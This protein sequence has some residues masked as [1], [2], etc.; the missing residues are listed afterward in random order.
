MAILEKLKAIIDKRSKRDGLRRPVTTDEVA[1]A[2]LAIMVAL[3]KLLEQPSPCPEMGTRVTSPQRAAPPILHV[4]ETPAPYT[5]PDSPP[6]L[7]S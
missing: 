4:S 7:Q 2:Q 6:P 3:V 5:K 1:E